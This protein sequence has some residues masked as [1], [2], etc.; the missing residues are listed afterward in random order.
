[1]DDNVLF[2]GIDNGLYFIGVDNSGNIG[3]CENWSF[4]L[5]IRFFRSGFTVSSENRV[6]GFEGGFSPHAETAQ[7]TSGG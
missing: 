5:V 2:D 6:E 3:V 1:M 7:L 4:E